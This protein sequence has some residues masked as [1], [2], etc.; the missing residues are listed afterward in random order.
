MSALTQLARRATYVLF[1]TAAIAA[2]SPLLFGSSKAADDTPWFEE[3]AAASGLD[4]AH[5]TGKRGKFWFPE[6]MGGGVAFV[7]VNGDDLLDIYCVQSGFWRE[8]GATDEEHAALG[9]HTNKLY[10][11]QGPGDDG[12]CTFQDITESAGVGHTGY[13]MGIACGDYDRDGM[14]DIYVTNV[15]PNVLY[16]NVSTK[17]GVKFEDV[18]DPN[19]S[20]GTW[21]TSAAFV[22]ADQDRDGKLDIFC[23][24][25]LGWSPGVETPCT[26]YYGAPDYCS[27][28]NYNAHQSDTLLLQGRLGF[29]DGTG[30]IVDHKGNGLGIAPCDFDDD[31]WVDIYVANDATP[32]VLWRNQAKTGKASYENVANQMACD[33]NGNGT[34]E[35]G[36]GV[37]W[38]DLDM[39]G[40]FDL[41]ITHLR[42]EKNTYYENRRN[43]KTGRTMFK[44]S[45]IK[46]GMNVHNS[47]FTGFGTGIFDFD[48][49][50]LL[51]VYVANGAV[52]QWASDEMF[53][54]DNAYA[55]PN[56]LFRGVAG[57]RSPKFE[58]VPTGGTA[59][60]LVGTSRGAAFGD[61]DNDGDMDVVYVDLDAQVRLLRNVAERQGNWIGFRVVD[62]SRKYIPGAKV[63]VTVGGKTLWRL[64]EPASSYLSSN[65]PRV[66]LGLGTADVIEDIVV[67]WPG[68]TE[69]H[70]DPL[71]M[72]QY[73]RLRMGKG[74]KEVTKD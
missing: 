47:R 39:D 33:V 34:P 64:A 57:K 22:Q 27:P 46:T 43:A 31:G 61:Y 5:V 59:T 66:H 69:E 35:A 62:K 17:D 49:D 26:N 16:H 44:D 51:D 1:P 6:I 60:D 21:S 67:R 2:G 38:A 68:G 15:G 73:H 71:E 11:N 23:V 56:H 48:L 72:G 3:V 9:V 53:A 42:R 52:Q 4:F 32:N 19:T 7:D 55:E 18:T 37:Q 8:P 28:E 13:G 24:N 29:R 40:D 58:L 10:L 30:S 45:S 25:N 41:F 12:N 14:I 70:F 63:G 20:I 65:D 74:R 54:A 50:G 36:M